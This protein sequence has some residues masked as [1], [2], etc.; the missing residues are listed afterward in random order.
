MQQARCGE[1]LDMS[2]TETNKTEEASPFKLQKAR[3]KGQV[4]RGPDLGFFSGLVALIMFIVMDG[5]NMAV[6]L[7]TMMA[8]TY[9]TA[10]QNGSD[11]AQ[12]HIV[13]STAR[14]PALQPVIGFCAIVFVVVVTLEI[15]QLRG[16]VFSSQ[17]LKPDFSRLN[18]GKGL[19]RVFSMRTLKETLKSV[20]KLAVYT[21]AATL[22]IISAIKTLAPTMTGASALVGAMYSEGL[23]LILVF[24]CLALVVAIID[25]IIAR[26]EFSKEMRMSR[27]ELTRESKEREGDPRQKQKRKQLHTE[28]ASQTQALGGVQGSD[29][30]IVNPE[31]VAIGL[32]YNSQTMS[33]PQVTTKG[34]NHFALLLKRK[35]ALLSVPIFKSPALA[36]ALFRSCEIG[37][38]VPAEFYRG[39][40]DIYLKLHA[41]KSAKEEAN[42]D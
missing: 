41:S 14:D 22:V 29:V 21:I 16:L 42:N 26:G 25:Q 5:P 33:A 12:M 19:K 17:A 1:A 35:A 23:R 15:I 24:A 36:R 4:A 20:I 32:A 38:D 2:E 34:R 3:E 7:S 8:R 6:Q 18:P 13:L 31:H 27:S 39:V 9:A 10:I 28:F 30:L 40:A 37:S 11:P